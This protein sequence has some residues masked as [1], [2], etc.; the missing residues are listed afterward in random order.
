[1]N[2][3]KKRGIFLAIISLIGLFVI[4]IWAISS[5]QSAQKTSSSSKV[6]IVAST[7]VW[8]DIASQVGG[9]YVEVTSILNDP[10]ADPHLYESDAKTASQIA[11]AQLIIVNGLG[12]DEFMD[13]L[14]AAAP[15]DQTVLKVSEVMQSSEDANPHLWY[16]LPRIQEVA[17][18]IQDELIQID[19]A[20]TAEYQRNTQQFI[21]NLQ[22]V[23]NKLTKLDGGIAYTE[24][25]AGYLVEDLGLT[26]KTPVGF[27]QAVESGT[28]PSPQ[29]VAEFEKVLKS[30]DIQVL[31][32]NNQA[33]NDVTE[34]LQEAARRAGVVVVGVSETI[35]AGKNFQSWQAA[36]L[37]AILEA[38]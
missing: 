24:R 27:T 20:H 13:K 10:E 14:L 31:L 30:G 18:A 35:P 33:V 12:Y 21:A 23:I 22:P 16:N 38:L 1:M 26:D 17:E 34:Q 25:V 36:Q 4:S 19:P 2:S 29:Q 3:H 8:G 7:N 15:Q 9:K 6:Q 32:Y 37:N 28:E 11:G 5:Y